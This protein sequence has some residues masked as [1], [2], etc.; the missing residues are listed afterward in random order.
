M[1]TVR[2]PCTYAV[3]AIVVV[4]VTLA[5]VTASETAKEPPRVPGTDPCSSRSLAADIDAVALAS[6]EMLT[7][8]VLPSITAPALTSIV[9]IASAWAYPTLMTWLPA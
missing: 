3:G 2:L 8:P 7:G 6:E 4:D 9:A 1:L 5:Q